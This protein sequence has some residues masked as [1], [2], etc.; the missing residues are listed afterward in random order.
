MLNQQ[1]YFGIFFA[2][3]MVSW[4]LPRVLVWKIVLTG[5]VLTTAFL[6]RPYFN[7]V[8]TQAVGEAEGAKNLDEI[9]ENK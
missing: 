7:C 9:S 5:L 1:R 4:L 8:K 2:I 6:V 3:A